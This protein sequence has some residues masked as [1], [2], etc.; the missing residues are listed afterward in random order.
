MPELFLGIDASTQSLSATI[1]DLS[2]GNVVYEASVNFEKDLPQY[3]TESGALIGS[4]PAVVHAPPLMWAEALDLL[5]QKMKDDGAPLSQILA[6]GGSGQQHGSV[7]LGENWPQILAGL[8]AGKTLAMQIKPALTRP[9]SP[10]WMDSST[11]TECYE[12]AAAFG[13]AKEVSIATGSGPIERFTGPQIRKFYKSEPDNYA[14]TAHIALVSSFIASILSGTIS[15]IDYGDG[16]GMNLMNIQ[17]RMWHQTALPATAPDLQK[18]LPSLAPATTVFST[19]S[20]YFAHKYGFAK[21][22][23]VTVFSGDNPCSLI[24][25][26]IVNEDVAAI[27]L[28]TSDTYFGCMKNCHTDPEAAGHVFVA[29]SGDYMSLICFKNGSLA[30]EKMAKIFNL[31]WDGFSRAMQ[32][33]PPGN[34]GHFLLPWFFPEITPC[35]LNAGVYRNGINEND[36]AENIRGVVEAQMMSM[37]LHSEWM[38]TRPKSILATGGASRNKEILQVMADVHGCS[39]IRRK[40]TGGA[41]LGAALMGAYG[42][43]QSQVSNNT[44]DEIRGVS[45]AEILSPFQEEAAESFVPNSTATQ[46]YEQILPLYADF[47]KSV[48]AALEK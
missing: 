47:E 32:I 21:T 17:T 6:I 33:T 40:N 9:T 5:L 31:D 43:Y 37:R 4:D 13:S 34:N 26:G 11:S 7:Y 8:S 39:V 29:P 19:I 20:P 42:W 48:R 46:A 38:G 28:G 45:W 27:S 44:K 22:T 23:L 18:R 2:A 35:V 41:G 10:I 25:L 36:A 24:A 16:A 12:L 1:I 15:P 30:R 3:E 14:R